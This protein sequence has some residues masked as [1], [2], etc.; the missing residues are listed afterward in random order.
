MRT[1][2]RIFAISQMILHPRAAPLILRFF[3][4]TTDETTTI[5]VSRRRRTLGI[6]RAFKE[7]VAIFAARS[8]RDREANASLLGEIEL[9]VGDTDKLFLRLRLRNLALP[10]ECVHRQFFRVSDDAARRQV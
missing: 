6:L 5:R 3:F 2:N 7:A 1:F 4:G 8:I 9:S 10:S